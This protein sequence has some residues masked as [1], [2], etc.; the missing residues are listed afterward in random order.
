MSEFWP[1]DPESRK[2]RQ[3][4]LY[5]PL[6]AL[7]LVVMTGL[8]VNYATTPKHI[9][10]H[11]IVVGGNPEE[12]ICEAVEK[13]SERNNI[14]VDINGCLKE[15]KGTEIPK[16]AIATVEFSRYPLVGDGRG[17]LVFGAPSF[18]VVPNK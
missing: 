18:E 14:P 15:F 10:E 11:S 5:K 7:A 12:D 8:G 17:H 16:D 6:T 4:R 1:Q 13:L 9:D 2:R 3:D